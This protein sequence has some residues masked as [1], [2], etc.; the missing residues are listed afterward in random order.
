MEVH[1]KKLISLCLTTMVVTGPALA[2]SSTGSSPASGTARETDSTLLPESST[3]SRSESMNSSSEKSKRH[4]LDTTGTI[5]EE[6][7][8]DTSTEAGSG[9]TPGSDSSTEP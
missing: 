2:Q 3:K 8:E 1:M 5:E 4:R 9:T 6:E 7:M